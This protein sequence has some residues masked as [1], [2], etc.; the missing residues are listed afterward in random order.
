MKKFKFVFNEAS[1]VSCFYFRDSRI[2]GYHFISCNEYENII[3]YCLDND[4]Y[5]DTSFNPE[6]ES[7]YISVCGEVLIYEKI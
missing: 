3:N 4:I 7:V 2:N 1:P 5:F 6:D